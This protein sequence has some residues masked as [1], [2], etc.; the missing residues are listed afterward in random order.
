MNI[1][2]GAG[3]VFRKQLQRTMPSLLPLSLLL[4]LCSCLTLARTV[5]TPCTEPVEVH[6]LSGPSTPVL[7]PETFSEWR[8]VVRVQVRFS[9]PVLAEFF[10]DFGEYYDWAEPVSKKRFVGRLAPIS[11]V[12][13]LASGD[14]VWEPT[15]QSYAGVSNDILDIEFEV[16]H[17]TAVQDVFFRPAANYIANI[18]S[19][20][21]ADQL[22]F[23]AWRCNTFLLSQ[24]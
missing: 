2:K 1:I 7:V 15:K 12:G 21:Q 3:A 11:F 14:Q 19:S 10:T 6:F 20:V 4:L 8:Q 5:Y 17:A 9:R 22:C 13:D 24:D 23:T 16:L 18:A